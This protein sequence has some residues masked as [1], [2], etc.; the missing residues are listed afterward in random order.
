[1]IVTYYF[2]QFKYVIK[3]HTLIKQDQDDN[4]KYLSI[5]DIIFD[6]LTTV[7][8]ICFFLFFLF[9]SGN[10]LKKKLLHPHSTCSMNYQPN[11]FLKE[12]QKSKDTISYIIIFPKR[13]SSNYTIKQ[14]GGMYYFN[15]LNVPF[16]IFFLKQHFK[17]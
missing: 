4:I 7:F 8:I 10:Y 15:T 12:G 17:V 3:A 5:H 6:I 14:G 2:F 9:F 13:N 1:M 16:K 11:R